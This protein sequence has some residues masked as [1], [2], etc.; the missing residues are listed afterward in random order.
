VSIPI[1]DL[2][3]GPG[4]LGEGFSSLIDSGGKRVFK[5]AISIEKEFHAHQTL[6][7]RAFVRAFD[8]GKVPA[9]YY[10]YLRGEITKIELF[11]AHPTE[12]KRAAAEAWMAELGSES[13]PN[14]LVDARIN[15]ALGK[16][17]KAWLL[18]GGPPCQAYSLVGRSRMMGADPKKYASDHRHFLYKEYLRILAI[19]QPPVFVM[20]NV[21]GLLS[22]SVQDEP[23]L[24]RI[25]EDLQ[26]PLAAV[27]AGRRANFGYRLH[28]LRPYED[29]YQK[30]VSNSDFLVNCEEHGLPQAR[31]R[32][33]IVGV[34]TD[35]AKVPQ[36]L[37][38]SKATSIE[39][40]IGDLPPL[41]GGLSREPDTPANWADAIRRASLGGWTRA[42]IEDKAL[43][44]DLVSRS[45]RVDKTL[46]RGG[47]FVTGDPAPASYR[48]WYVDK[49]LNG[50]CNHESRGH[51]RGDLCR[52]FFAASF[53]LKHKR[54]PIMKDF[55]K[56]LLPNHRNID[57]AIEGSK[58][59]DRFRVQTMGRPSTTIVSHV[60]KDGHYFIHYDPMQCR[61]LT[62]R[63][64]AR[65]QTFPDNYF[66]EGPRTEQ[67][68]QVGNAVPPLLAR[69]I[70][71]IVADLF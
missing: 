11:A 45:R 65:L 33:I 15:G 57:E 3:A 48:S 36:L 54:T 25:L 50:F 62:V 60:S 49:K 5:I 19:H 39:D 12:A 61:S 16:R 44:A 8:P 41:R 66:F 2:F 1:V 35:S 67:Y 46:G 47:R 59:G 71:E 52:Y 27:Q 42:G 22:A 13:T 58:F 51:M 56:S 14:S 34:R 6:E 29:L 7:L 9:D 20:E 31:H 23:T 38:L 69:Q 37:R 17:S 28:T 68:R 24:P 43:L 26:N 30:L 21:K 4:G 18:I 63:E 53:A 70:A 32:L 64:A 55:P 10:R 40:V